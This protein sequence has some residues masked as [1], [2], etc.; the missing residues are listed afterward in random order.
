MQPSI[1]TGLNLR[2]STYS[3]MAVTV[4]SFDL[5]HGKKHIT[6]IR[7]SKKKKI[8][9]WQYPGNSAFSLMQVL[10]IYFKL[11]A[12]EKRYK[13]PKYRR[14]WFQVMIVSPC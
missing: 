5:G 6:S 11:I 8:C 1:L 9:A 2:D 14:A 10:T 12:A 3:F 4:L 13:R 7:V